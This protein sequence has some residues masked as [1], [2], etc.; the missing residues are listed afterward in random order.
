LALEVGER[1]E[2]TIGRVDEFT[3]KVVPTFLVLF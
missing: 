1:V 2:S 3:L